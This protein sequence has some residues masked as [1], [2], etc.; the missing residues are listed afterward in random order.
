MAKR[1]A[2]GEGSI[3]KKQNG[4]WEGRIVVDRKENGLPK[5]IL[6][7]E[8]MGIFMAEIKKKCDMARLLLC[9]ND[10]R[11]APQ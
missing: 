3:R 4:L 10:H 1:R 5:R 11:P 8:E 2:N 6:A 7:G 9:R